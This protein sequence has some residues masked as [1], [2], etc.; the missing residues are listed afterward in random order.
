MGELLESV[1]LR[2]TGKGELL[3]S[4]SLMGEL[5]ERVSLREGVVAGW[6]HSLRTKALLDG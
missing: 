5:L 3:D 2:E 1:S 6:H 4:K